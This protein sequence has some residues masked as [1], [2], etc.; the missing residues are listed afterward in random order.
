MFGHLQVIGSAFAAMHGAQVAEVH[1]HRHAC[2]SAGHGL[3][4]QMYSALVAVLCAALM[5][6]GRNWR[7]KD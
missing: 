4:V 2:R 5:S 7:K 3:L 6:I 1:V